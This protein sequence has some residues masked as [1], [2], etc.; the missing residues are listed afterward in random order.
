MDTN[1]SSVVASAIAQ[2]LDTEKGNGLSYIDFNY[3]IFPKF[4]ECFEDNEMEF[5]TLLSSPELSLMTMVERKIPFIFLFLAKKLKPKCERTDSDFIEVKFF[6]DQLK[7]NGT[8][9]FSVQI[10]FQNGI[11]ENSMKIIKNDQSE[12]D[13]TDLEKKING[14]ITVYEKTYE[15]LSDEEFSQYITKYNLGYKVLQDYS[16]AI[17]TTS[18]IN[19]LNKLIKDLMSNESNSNASKNNN[20]NNILN[21]L[22]E[23]PGISQASFEA[24]MKD[25]RRC[26]FDL[27]PVSVLKDSEAESCL[28]NMIKYFSTN[29][30]YSEAYYTISALIKEFPNSLNIGDYNDLKNEIEDNLTKAEIDFPQKRPIKKDHTTLL[31][32]GEIIMAEGETGDYLYFLSEG[33]VEVK[34]ISQEGETHLATLYAPDVFGEMAIISDQRRSATIV[35]KEDV[36]LTTLTKDGFRLL[37]EEKGNLKKIDSSVAKVIKKFKN[38]GIHEM[39]YQALSDRINNTEALY[40]AREKFDD[41]LEKLYVLLGKVTGDFV[42]ENGK[43]FKFDI[44]ELLLLADIKTKGSSTKIDGNFSLADLLNRIDVPYQ[45]A[46]HE[47]KKIFRL[48]NNRLFCSDVKQLEKSYNEVIKKLLLEKAT[49]DVE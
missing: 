33:S 16:K 30:Q 1:I 17:E 35:A 39:I 29:K 9:I 37:F 8:S 42:E 47:N 19:N 26:N 34:K 7:Q 48:Q 31:K 22:A 43:L 28:L 24:L 23:N 10:K 21:L 5:I 46:V 12:I 20:K 41:P 6:V 45:T 40:V 38:S 15:A 2:Y 32:E 25:L 36:T 44:E 49:N 27:M 3:T 4:I 14:L 13:L 18:F 11:L